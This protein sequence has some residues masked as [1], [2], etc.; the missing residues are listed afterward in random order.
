MIRFLKSIV[1]WGETLFIG[2]RFPEGEECSDISVN[3][4]ALI[5]RTVLTRRN[6][7]YANPSSVLIL[8]YKSKFSFSNNLFKKIRENLSLIS[9]SSFD[10]KCELRFK[11]R[12]SIRNW[13]SISRLSCIKFQICDIEIQFWNQSLIFKSKLDFEIDNFD[14][15]I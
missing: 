3:S 14:F 10:F 15:E 1:F 11:N 7:V 5:W 12:V 2:R 8:L 9:K 6:M 4:A 13:G